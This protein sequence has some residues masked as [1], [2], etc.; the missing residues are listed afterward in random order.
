M[1]VVVTGVSSYLASEI[2]PLL[3]KDDII[4]KV[5][6]LDIIKPKYSHPKLEFKKRDVRDKK[7]EEDL[8][9]YDVL[10]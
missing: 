10:G 6:G 1:K 3:E 7:L 5:L 2:L 9:G 8:K 4:E